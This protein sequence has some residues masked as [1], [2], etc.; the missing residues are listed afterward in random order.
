[1]WYQREGAR[2]SK[3]LPPGLSHEDQTVLKSVRRYAYQ[4]DLAFDSCC[5]WKLGWGGLMGLI[6]WIGDIIVLYFAYSLIQKAQEVEGGLPK[7]IEAQMFAN[8]S[9]DFG[10]G[11]IPILGDL[12]NIAY[13]GN[14]RN[15][16]ILENYLRKRGE[17]RMKE[18][19]MTTHNPQPAQGPGSTAAV[20]GGA[21]PK[22]GPP[23]RVGNSNKNEATTV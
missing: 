20:V 23:T 3:P 4:L 19:G 7:Y 17:K 5:G 22:N 14:T 18:Q 15:C 8:M 9:F 12:I 10:I 2:R 6:P 13:K 16:L 11:L 1:M 21:E